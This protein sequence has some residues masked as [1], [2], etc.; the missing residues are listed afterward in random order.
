MNIL[1]I[2]NIDRNI[3][4]DLMVK[5]VANSLKPNTVY[6]LKAEEDYTIP[7]RNLE[8]IKF[9][10]ENDYTSLKAI[11]KICSKIDLIILL[12]GSLF[13]IPT[14]RM[15]LHYLKIFL[16]F[17]IFR[18]CGIKLALINCNVGPICCKLGL[19]TVGL[20]V[21]VFNIATVRDS[22]SY[23]L[24]KKYKKKNLFFFPDIVLTY[25][26]IKNT[27]PNKDNYSCLG[28]SIYNPALITKKDENDYINF[29]AK[30]IKANLELDAFRVVK[31]FAFSTGSEGDNLAARAVFENMKNKNRVEL[32]EYS[33]DI[34]SFL[35]EISKCD[36]FIPI[37]FHSLILA[38]LSG[39]PCVPVS[40]DIKVSNFLR[41]INFKNYFKFEELKEINTSY[42]I[43]KL[44]EP[45]NFL[46]SNMLGEIRNKA[47]GHLLVLQS[48]LNSLE[49]TKS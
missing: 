22:E 10:S 27:K 6:L 44:N 33:G 45:Q 32:V 7:F 34:D 29:F 35:D 39:I 36:L 23:R 38:L 25:E 13:K 3:G 2:A 48:F 20:I 42:F 37:R 47:R 11:K 17:L 28:I 15:I 43:E 41:D 26:H 8:N 40:Y 12:G 30:I 46:T 21:K 19:L 9:I 31:I 49:R 18:L 5:I 4:D 14:K 1:I 24:M 16:V